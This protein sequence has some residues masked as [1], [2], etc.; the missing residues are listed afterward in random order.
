MPLTKR[1]LLIQPNLRPLY[2]IIPPFI[3]NSYLPD[4]FTKLKK[5][6]H[7]LLTKCTTLIRPKLDSLLRI[8]PSSF[9]TVTFASDIHTLPQMSPAEM[10]RQ[11]LHSAFHP[12]K[13][14]SIYIV[15]WKMTGALYKRHSRSGISPHWK[16]Y[17]A[18]CEAIKTCFFFLFFRR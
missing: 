10:N 13:T 15:G 18:R 14:Q 8:I 6:Y 1:T 2:R 16:G 7:L 4:D 12:Q 9:T 5:T 3:H 17:V 11:P